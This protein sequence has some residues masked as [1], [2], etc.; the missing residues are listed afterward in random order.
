MFSQLWICS[1][2]DGE[3][4]I[5]RKGIFTAF[6]H[7]RSGL[8]CWRCFCF[9]ANV[10]SKQ[11]QFGLFV[12]SAN[13]GMWFLC[14]ITDVKVKVFSSPLCW[15]SI[16]EKQPLSYFQTLSSSCHFFH[17]CNVLFPRHFGSSLDVV[18]IAKMKPSN[19]NLRGSLFSC[20]IVL[21]C[22]PFSLLLEHTWCTTQ[23]SFCLC[24]LC[25]NFCMSLHRCCTLFVDRRRVQLL[26][27][28]MK[29]YILPCVHQW[30]WIALPCQPANIKYYKT[31]LKCLLWTWMIN[32][33]N[34]H[35]DP[36]PGLCFNGNHPLDITGLNCW[37]IGVTIQNTATSRLYTETP[38]R[39]LVYFTQSP[40]YPM[41][42]LQKSGFVFFL[43]N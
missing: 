2:S 38:D 3:R 5:L 12:K 37:A 16:W 30:W 8:I 34:T 21:Y 10:K 9:C 1:L 13:T 40:L 25:L 17:H 7:F 11:L 19:F 41:L 24:L 32:T 18:I 22:H 28:Y 42:I 23:R 33:P 35:K 36:K 27:H 39:M 4:Q 31:Y 15:V 20:I 26:C 14:K 29:W 43:I 6:I